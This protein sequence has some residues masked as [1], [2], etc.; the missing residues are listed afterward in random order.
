MDADT[1]FKEGME[2]FK[3]E[4]YF[5]AAQ[6]WK[7]VK[8]LRA[9]YPNVEMYLNVCERKQVQT[10]DYIQDVD[11]RLFEKVEDDDNQLVDLVTESEKEFNQLVKANN[12]DKAEAVLEVLKFERPTDVRSLFFLVKGYRIVGNLGQLLACAQEIVRIEPHKARSHAVLGT[13]YFQ[14][15]HFEQAKQAYIRAHKLNSHNFLVLNNL[16]VVCEFL[17]QIDEARKYYRLALGLQPEN[18]GLEEKISRLGQSLKELDQEVL[19]VCEELEKQHPYPDTLYKLGML[20]KR[21]GKLE[22]S[23]YYLEKAIASNPSYQAAQYEVGKLC[24]SFGEYHRALKHF[25]K[26]LE[27]RGQTIEDFSNVDQFVKAGYLEEA[28]SEFVRVLKMEPDY[29]ALHIEMGKQ[30]FKAKRYDQAFDELKK[31][32][33]LRPE[34]PDGQYYLGLCFKHNGQKTHALEHFEEAFDLNPEYFLPAFEMIP[35]LVLGNENKKAKQILQR[36]QS[37]CDKDSEDYVKAEDL[38]KELSE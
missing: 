21:A 7:A 9:D 37:C 13:V 4:Q 28:A 32:V 15:E 11:H 24:V 10:E 38:L 19:T 1:L 18:K 6:R 29:G 12:L 36:V 17:K 20:Y 23:F 33:H 27:L 31:G 14:L 16:G 5:E 3:R 2:F 25:D 35:L 26:I 34:Y 30:H 8:K 22:K